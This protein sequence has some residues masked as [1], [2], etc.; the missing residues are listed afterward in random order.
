MV[1]ACK[2]STSPDKLYADTVNI[3]QDYNWTNLHL[4]GMQV[5]THI[6]E[7]LGTSNPKADY[8]TI[9]PGEEYTYYFEVPEDHPPGTHWS[10]GFTRDIA[11]MRDFTMA[12]SASGTRSSFTV[13]AE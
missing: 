11:S 12:R 7:P 3:P 2:E 10:L 13:N 9:K 8:I 1:G 4:H 5:A 6:F